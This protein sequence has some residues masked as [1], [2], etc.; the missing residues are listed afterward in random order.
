MRG[1]PDWSLELLPLWLYEEGMKKKRIADWLEKM[2]AAFF[3]GTVLAQDGSA[4][5]FVFGVVCLWI[6]LRLTDGGE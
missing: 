1:H 5:S 4:L 6:S 3:V 2:S